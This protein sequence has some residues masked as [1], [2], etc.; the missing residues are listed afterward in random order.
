VLARHQ[1]HLTRLF[2]SAQREPQD[3]PNLTRQEEAL[4]LPPTGRQAQKS[5]QNR[6]QRLARYH[7]VVELR[8][9]G[10]KLS[11]IAQQVGI[12]EQTVNR[13]LAAGHFP[14]RTRRRRQPSLLNHY[15]AYLNRRWAE[16]CHNAT[17]LCREIRQ[18]GYKGSQAL[19]LNYAWRRRRGRH[20]HTSNEW[21]PS[22]AKPIRSHSYSPRQAAILFVSSPGELEEETQRALTAMRQ[23][24]RE[25]RQLYELSQRFAQMIRQRQVDSF[26]PWR[27]AAQASLLPELRQFV[28]G[29]LRD[30]AAVIA[31]LKYP[32]SNGPVE[33]H[34]NRLKLIKRQLFGR[35]NFDLLRLRVLHP[36]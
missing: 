8:Q 33:G 30:K 24:C 36:P 20:I 19:V 28:S 3:T 10:L 29:L 11:L 12:S 14:A 7:Q 21:Q 35:A 17:Q 23:H 32:W 4:A 34:I 18:Q 13:W 25:I 31:A 6:A 2:T 5:Q 1:P 27:Q 26:D 15:L 16:G 22:E 9:K